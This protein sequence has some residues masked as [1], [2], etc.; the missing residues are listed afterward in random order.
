MNSSITLLS[1]QGHRLLQIGIA[2]FL[3]SSFDGFAIPS[4]KLKILVGVRESARGQG[5]NLAMA[6]YAYLELFRHGAKYLS[7]TLVLDD[8]WR[9]RRTAES[10]DASC[11][12][13]T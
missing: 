7:Y 2:L 6:A 12:P 9:S 4:E 8:K 1:H 11:A 10:L 13:I 5:V 3:Y